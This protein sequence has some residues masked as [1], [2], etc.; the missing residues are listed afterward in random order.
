M[1]KRTPGPWKWKGPYEEE[2]MAP[3][4]IMLDDNG[5]CGDSE[6]CGDVTYH[7]VIGEA[8]ARLIEA[9]PD[10]LAACKGLLSL[11]AGYNSKS[12]TDVL[13]NARAAIAKVEEPTP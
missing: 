1:S 5:A 9:A 13:N 11:S 10:L 2:A 12:L 6:C 7:I 4:V 8:D 3:G